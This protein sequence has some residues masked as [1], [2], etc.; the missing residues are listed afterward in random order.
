MLRFV[1]SGHTGPDENG[2]RV[3]DP[4]FDILTMRTLRRN[5]ICQIRY[6]LRKISADQDIDRMAG[7]G[8]QNIPVLF[9]QDPVIFP[10]H[11]RRADPGFF[12]IRKPQL[13]QRLPHLLNAHPFIIGDKGRIEACNH[14]HTALDHYGHLASFVF[15][16]LC[17]LRTDHSALAAIDA[18]IL[19]DMCLISG[20]TDRFHRTMPD[21]FITVSAVRFFQC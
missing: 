1:F 5:D 16:L 6:Q 19:D 21:A 18:V 9:L 8:D 10:L 2:L 12:D 14:R 17:V 3:R 7:R 13:A 11:D 20:K 4:F 15:D